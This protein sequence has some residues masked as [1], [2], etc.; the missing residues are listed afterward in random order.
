MG[1]NAFPKRSDLSRRN[2]LLT[3]K[4][5]KKQELSS[6]AKVVV[7]VRSNQNVPA[8][9]HGEVET[10]RSPVLLCSLMLIGTSVQAG[11]KHFLTAV[12]RA[13][14]RTAENMVTFK[15]R[16]LALNQWILMT[17]VLID[18]KTSLDLTH[19][20]PVPCENYGSV[21]GAHP[22]AARVYGTLGLTG[23]Y[24]STLNQ[25]AWEVSDTEDDPGGRTFERYFMLTAAVVHARF[26]IRN[27]QIQPAAY[28]VS[29]GQNK[30]PPELRADH[31]I[32]Q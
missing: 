21:W 13:F 6:P 17:T 9:E 28:S 5:R 29:A 3:Q 4:A 26:A 23:V 11:P 30:L 22:S 15:D 12:P 10:M 14:G 20:C 25:V 2:V 18:A 8:H 24:Y 7:F 16:G 32:P 19:R 1:R 27:T 31:V